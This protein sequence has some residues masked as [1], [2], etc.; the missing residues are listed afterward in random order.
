M[1]AFA[2]VTK[3]YLRQESVNSELEGLMSPSQD[4]I[5]KNL[6]TPALEIAFWIG[7]Y[8]QQQYRRNFLNTNQLVVMQH[9]LDDM[10]KDFTKLSPFMG[11]TLTMRLLDRRHK[12]I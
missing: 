6:S 3:L 10:V 8:L 5:L 7:D 11:R 1:V 4:F 9:L 12:A 2:V